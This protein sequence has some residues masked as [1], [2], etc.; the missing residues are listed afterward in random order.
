MDRGAWWATVHGVTRLGYDLATKQ[1]QPERQNADWLGPDPSRFRGES[2]KRSHV[3]KY[4]SWTVPLTLVLPQMS[5]GVG[6]SPKVLLGCL[7]QEVMGA[8][9]QRIFD[10][11]KSRIL[12]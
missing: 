7:T 10:V 12:T 6:R 5:H 2:W 1:Q 8:Y 4:G 3:V 11:I 9:V